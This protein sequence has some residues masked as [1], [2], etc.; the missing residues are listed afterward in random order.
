MQRTLEVF[1]L[2]GGRYTLFGVFKDAEVVNA[3]PFEV[4]DLELTVLWADVVQTG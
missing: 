3:M 4:L 1:Q 2:D